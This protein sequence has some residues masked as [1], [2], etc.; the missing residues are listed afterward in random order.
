MKRNQLRAFL[1]LGL[2]VAPIFSF[3][4]ALANAQ[5]MNQTT[6]SP[7]FLFNRTNKLLSITYSLCEYDYIRNKPKSENTTCSQSTQLLP[8]NGYLEFALETIEVT[9]YI[10]HVKNAFI[11]KVSDEEGNYQYFIKNWDDSSAYTDYSKIFV[12]GV[13][14]VASYCYMFTAQSIYLYATKTGFL[15]A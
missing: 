5:V 7:S 10:T 13:H 12:G 8:V 2:F 9:D 3:S 6:R 14:R 15:C 11:G 4:K 1:M